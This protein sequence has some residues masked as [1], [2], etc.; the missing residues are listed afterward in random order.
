MLKLLRNMLSFVVRGEIQVLNVLIIINVFPQMYMD[1]L[2][3]KYVLMIQD[4]LSDWLLVLLE[5]LG[6]LYSVGTVVRVVD[7]QFSLETLE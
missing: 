4:D 6:M 1:F 3:M 5:F 7:Q 2:E